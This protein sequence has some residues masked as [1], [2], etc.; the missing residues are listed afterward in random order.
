MLKKLLLFSVFLLFILG[1]SG[2]VSAANW[3]VGSNGTYQSIQAAID[4]NNTLEN[5]TIIVNP[6]SSGSYRE[7]LRISKG[8]LHLVANG[9]VTINASN[10]NLP[11]VT[12]NYNG[13]GSTIWGF[14]LI[15]GKSGIVDYAD[16]CQITGNNITI[17]TPG[18]DY[19]GGIDSGY[20]VDGGV[21]VEGSNVVIKGN[22]INGNRDNVKGIMIVASNSNITGNSILNAAFGI[23]FGG[24]DG[25]NV[26]S[27]NITGCY[28]GI[29]IESNDYFFASNNCQIGNNAI[30]NSSM[31]SIRISGVAGDE[32]V[33]SDIQIIGNNITNNG[34]ISEQTGGGIYLNHDTSNITISGNNVINNWNGIELGNIDEISDF[35]PQNGNIIT[36]NT[37]K[38]NIGNGIDIK[39]SN[40]NTIKSNNIENNGIGISISN[41]SADINFNR[42]T[43]NSLYGL[44]TEFNSTI[45]AT[46]N[47]WGSNNPI[48]ALTNRSDI[49][50]A[51]GTATYDPWLILNIITTNINQNSSQY[52][53]VTADITHNS[54]GEDTSSQGNIP[55]DIP[56][57]FITS[58]GT[59][60]GVAY[61]KNGKANTTFNPGTATSGVANIAA[62]MD[63]QIVQA[64]IT[65]D[66]I[67]PTVNASLG[68]GTYTNYQN[69][70]LTASDNYD[71]NPVIY[72]TLDGTNPTTGSN[73]YTAPIHIVKNSTT[74]KFIAVDALGN[75][76]SVQTRIY[77]IDLPVMNLNTSIVYSTIGAAIN[78]SLTLNGHTIEIK[79]GT[80]VENIVVNKVLI[81]RPA[82]GASVTV[83]P[84]NTSL[85]VININSAGSGSTIQGLNINGITASSGIYLSG[86]S[87][88]NIIGNNLVSNTG[89]G[90]YLVN[91]SNNNISGN[92]VSYNTGN[93]IYLNNGSNY[94]IISG[95]TA[96]YNTNNGIYLV[97]SSNNIIS[98][99][100]VSNNA[101]SG[102]YISY[103]SSSNQIKNNN[104]TA[105]TN[106][107]IALRDSSINNTAQNNDLSANHYGVDVYSANNNNVQNNRVINN[108][109]GMYLGHSNSTLITGNYITGST[110]GINPQYS[111]ATI[112][113]NSLVGNSRFSLVNQQNS[114]V[115]ATNNWWGDNTPSYISSP[116][117]VS[118]NYDIYNCNSTLTY[119]PWL[120]LSVTA[121]PKV[122]KDGNSTITADLT[123]N[124]AGSSTSSQGHIPDNIPV[125]FTTSIGTITSLVYTVNGKA[126]VTFNRGTLTS[127]IA[128]IKAIVDNQTVQT[129]VTIDTTAPTVTANIANGT[130]TA[131]QNVTLTAT[132][133]VDPSPAI[134]YTLD[135]T[136]PT[137]SS[138]RYTAPIR[139]NKKNTTLKFIAVDS[140]GNQASVQTRT[141]TL[142][143]PVIN[144]NTTIVYS[145]IQAA[146]SDSST[147]NGHTIEVKNG[148]YTVSLEINKNIVLKPASGAS[149]TLQAP[150]EI[151]DV[152]YI[153]P[154]GAGTV[155]QGFIIKGNNEGGININGASNCTIIGN[156]ITNCP[157]GI[158]IYGNSNYN[159][160]KNNKI[161]NS[162]IDGIHLDNSNYNIIQNNT[163]TGSYE[164]GIQISYSNYNIIQNNIIANNTE[165]G[166]GKGIFIAS[167]SNNTIQNNTITNNNADGILSADSSDNNIQSNIITN[168]GYGIYLTR[169]SANINF[170]RITGNRNI[171]IEHWIGSGTIVNATNN[172]WGHN[173]APISGSN[174]GSDYYSEEGTFIVGP[175][176]VL[177]IT[178]NPTSTNNSSTITAD[179]THNSNG[180][181]T[182]ALGHVPDNILVN[183]T[184]SLGTI[185]S[186]AYTKN[187]KVSVTFS[188]GTSTSGTVAVTATLDKQ[189]AKTNITIDTISPTVTTV[190]PGNNATNVPV[191]KVI[192][193]ILSESV[194]AGNN[195]IRLQDNNGTIVPVT[196]SISGNILTVTPA[197]LLT[198]GTTY[199]LVIS[200]GSITDLAG[201]NIANYVTSFTSS[202]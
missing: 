201:N 72:Y 47:W 18:S 49:Y 187:G 16:D 110:Y 79:S 133:N 162:G 156:T 127:G 71:P 159:T 145:N 152:I 27:N 128:I 80:Y 37:I 95:N 199:S 119:N 153:E 195:L 89:N 131:Y 196:V 90:I 139:I 173:T 107:G 183:F 43:G 9:S 97:N 184:T 13:A 77:V 38:D 143:L 33:I 170:N 40:G 166:L 106:Y 3:T 176:L 78:D 5:D 14:N 113:F 96:S 165:E 109:Y 189:S 149:V 100:T 144:L 116:N 130:Y 123:H 24:A 101:N 17:G 111:S 10:Y 73:R 147:L 57:S 132:D 188:R 154:N 6:R 67:A 138:T 58:L 202:T 172:W 56:V 186:S 82:S 91:S 45:N 180:E 84:E 19:S 141:Y 12:I 74:L 44:Y 1:V 117:W 34:N 168:N 48:I 85:S 25:C 175:W 23:L 179:L 69:I 102:M 198:N 164:S 8:K 118:A 171:G 193:V 83:Q 135:G 94:N 20:T 169:S 88:C 55:D 36:E 2:A 126:S 185:T 99:N 177:N 140:V 46:N 200:A 182:L 125:K 68:N 104:A 75:Q 81:I 66:T 11:V 60:T 32:N 174:D 178:A 50:I 61:T 163:V 122:I 28:Y 93:G 158:F 194:K 108:F 190:D 30:S 192:K 98:G 35:Q 53:V 87:G 167:S 112:H 161:T 134:Y 137:T 103:S 64:N 22:K 39:N 150:S 121:S 120:V 76:S 105:N 114:T 7:N 160:I 157:D 191:N 31:Y 86:A 42:I 26:T 151:V 29:D 4:S 92:T 54:A 41:S 146:I 148:T 52:P 115:D 197:S 65:I 63:N 124:N 181:D 59:I 129:N 15:G 142:N 51:N 136:T 70:T 155:I 21:A 62:T